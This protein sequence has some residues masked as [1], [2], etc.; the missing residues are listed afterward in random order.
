MWK[1]Q[2]TEEGNP[3]KLKQPASPPVLVRFTPLNAAEVL[4]DSPAAGGDGTIAFRSEADEGLIRSHALVAVGRGGREEVVT[5]WHL[6][7][8][9]C[10]MAEVTVGSKATRHFFRRCAS[11][12]PA[13]F[14]ATP[15]APTSQ[16]R[17]S[18]T[19]NPADEARFGADDAL[20]GS[21][22]TSGDVD[23]SSALTPER[24]WL[25][26]NGIGMRAGSVW[27]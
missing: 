9:E 17:S 4:V 27:A 21:H 6:E 8:D 11:P 7:S 16:R 3:R 2:A 26:E 5:Q 25:R 18:G 19:E 13:A 22:A 24:R 15:A 20:L 14:A 1:M 23:A 12:A 10:L